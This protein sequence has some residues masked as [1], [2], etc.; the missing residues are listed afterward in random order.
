MSIHDHSI[1]SAP[2][3][4][5][6]LEYLQILCPWDL[7]DLFFSIWDLPSKQSHHVPMSAGWQ[8]VAAAEIQRLDTD[9]TPGR[10]VFV[11]INPRNRDPGPYERGKKEDIGALLG[12]AIDVDVGTDHAKKGLPLPPTV[13]D[14]GD[15]LGN[16]PIDITLAVRS[17]H[18]VHG[19][20]LFDKP[21]R[22][23]AGNRSIVAKNAQDFEAR[24]RE[25]FETR[26]WHL[27]KVADPPRVL[28]PARTYNRKL[29]DARP[30]ELFADAGPRHSFEALRDFAT[31]PTLISVPASL[32]ASAPTASTPVAP[33]VVD[34]LS[35]MLSR[36]PDAAPPPAASSA[37]PVAT[38]VDTRTEAEIVEAARDKLRRSR[39]A[40][41]RPIIKNILEGKPY[42]AKGERDRTTQKDILDD[43]IGRAHV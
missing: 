43:E 12:F 25:R 39:H 23:D 6:T 28:R 3:A 30:V 36:A 40:D 14:A 38:P 32:P 19:Y 31:R 22:L 15:V 27:D 17:G 8:D 1:I 37:E 10:N 16:L 5:E 24:I 33:S 41:R 35:A 20:Y 18:G 21:L 11:G 34:A 29:A 26:G 4:A 7:P 13:A 9:G 42:A 2:F